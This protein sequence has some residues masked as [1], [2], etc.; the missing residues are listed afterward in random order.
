MN[1][2]KKIELEC[3]NLKSVAEKLEKLGKLLA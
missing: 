3:M 2:I 1:Q